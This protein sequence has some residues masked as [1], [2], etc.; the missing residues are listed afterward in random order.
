MRMSLAALTLMLILAIYSPTQAAES[1]AA[2]SGSLLGPLVAQRSSDGMTISGMIRKLPAGTKMWVM[3]IHEPGGPQKAVSGPEDDHVL[4]NSEGKFEA[5]IHNPSSAAFKPGNYRVTIESHF[6]SGW[7]TADVLRKAG[8][9]LDRQ[10]RSSIYTDPK[11][12]PESPDFKPFDTEFPNAGRYLKA[13][14]EVS[15]GVPPLD[16]AAIEGV[17][18][19]TLLVQGKGRSSLPVGQSVQVFAKAGGFT[20]TAWSAAPGPDSKWVVTLDCIDGGKPTK[21]QWS[22]DPRSK[23]VKYLDHAAKTLSYVPAD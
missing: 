12:I 23:I 20:P 5:N 18:R 15:L 4:V 13:V 1:S 10:G 19:A 3:I 2:A 21:A 9:Q 16:Q 8:V 17:K 7:Q 22:Y 6:T 14:R 11:A